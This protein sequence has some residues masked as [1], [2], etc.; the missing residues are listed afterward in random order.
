MLLRLAPAVAAGRAI[1]AAAAVVG[2]SVGHFSAPHAHAQLPSFVLA[3][4]LLLGTVWRTN[5]PR[6]LL[7]ASLGAQVLVHLIGVLSAHVALVTP[8]MVFFHSVTAVIAW[9]LMWKFEALWDSLNSAMTAVFGS[10]RLVVARPPG[11]TLLPV[12]FIGTHRM[13]LLR[14]TLTRRGPPVLA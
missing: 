5:S 12:S 14:L 4:F 10:R 1:F 3:F 6:A 2:S 11:V 13:R 7:A 8:G 9:V